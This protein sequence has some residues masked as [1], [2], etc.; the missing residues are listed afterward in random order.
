MEFLT[1]AGDLFNSLVGWIVGGS[2]VPDPEFSLLK[3]AARP[4]VM[5]IALVIT[6][7][8]LVPKERRPWGKQHML[9]LTHFIMSSKVAL[10]TFITIPAMQWAWIRFSLPSLHLDRSLHPA[11]FVILTLLVMGLVDYTSHRM[12][13]RVPLLW[14]IHKIHH[15]PTQLTW[16]SSFQ[17]HFAMTLTSAP[18]LTAST[19]LLGVHLV[20]P[21]G[22]VFL[23]VNYLQH[24]NI[25]LRFGWLNYVFALPEIHRYHHSR[26]PRDYDT[27]FGGGFVFW[28]MVF[29][30]FRYDPKDPATE[31]G[32]DEDVPTQWHRQQIEPLKWIAR[33]LKRSFTRKTTA[34]PRPDSISSSQ[35]SGPPSA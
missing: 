18:L 17:E 3:W 34:A 26:N 31:F 7:E 32:L 13:H 9:T 15:A 8:L 28:D 19:L 23:L 22:S 20:P 27:N 29:G 14:H 5:I 35:L 33:D 6:L 25:S 11:V 12:L 16:A 10:F 2:L 4:V 30:T 1:S 21:W 24:A